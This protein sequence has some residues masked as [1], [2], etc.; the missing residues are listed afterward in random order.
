M[1]TYPVRNQV[2]LAFAFEIENAYIGK[3]KAAALLRSVSGV[4]DVQIRKLFGPDPDVHIEFVYMGQAFIVWEPY[5]DS[6]RF[7]IGPKDDL[8][9][10]IDLSA[11]EAAFRQHRPFL[12]R[13]LLGDL[14]TAKFLTILRKR[15]TS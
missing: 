11:L 15:V 8:Q 6:S 5:A 12:V 7:W 14:L 1:N 4:S 9:D 13:K 3:K 2:G 10:Q